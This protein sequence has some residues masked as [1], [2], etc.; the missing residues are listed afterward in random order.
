MNNSEGKYFNTALCLAEALI[1]LPEVKGLEYITV[2]EIGE[3]ADVNRPT[4]YLHYETVSDI[5]F[6][7]IFFIFS[8]YANISIS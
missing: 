2:K 7:E 1:A 5:S 3:K 6:I 4:F 8:E